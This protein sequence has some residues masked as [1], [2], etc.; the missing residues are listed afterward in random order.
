MM[1]MGWCFV[2]LAM[3][4]ATSASATTFPTSGTYAASIYVNQANPS[5]ACWDG[6]GATY[7]GVLNYGGLDDNHAGLRVPLGAKDAVSI[8]TLTAKAGLG[9]LTPSGTFTWKIVASYGAPRTVTGTWSAK[10]TVIDT[11]SFVADIMEYYNGNACTEGLN[12]SLTRVG[13]HQN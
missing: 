12:V 1:R 3:F 2:G 9:T 5:Y 10:L 11:V 6:A 7:A 8:Q 4:A 13:P